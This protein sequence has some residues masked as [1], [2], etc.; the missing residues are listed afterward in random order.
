MQTIS[1]VLVVSRPCKALRDRHV[2]VARIE[3]KNLSQLQPQ[4]TL[5]HLVSYFRHVRD[6]D[7]T[8]DS[9]YLGEL[10]ANSAERYFAKFD[11]LHTVRVPTEQ[12]KRIDFI[13]THRRYRL[14]PDF[15]HDLQQRLFRAFASLGFDDD[16]WW[17]DGDLGYLVGKGRAAVRSIESK[18]DALN[19]ELKGIE[20]A[21]KDE[22]SVRAQLKQA[23][24]QLGDERATLAPL[25]LEHERRFGK[26]T[27]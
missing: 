9:F 19:S 25:E 6:G 8:P 11:A 15:V 3:K 17:S 4:D 27:D 13:R 1:D 24:K 2:I 26:T 16:R 14:S 22:K 21:G 7:G 10:E 5:E 12:P 18:I 23:E 20:L